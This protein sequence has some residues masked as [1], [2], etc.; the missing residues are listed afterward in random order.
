MQRTRIPVV[1]LGEGI[2]DGGVHVGVVDRP[3]ALSRSVSDSGTSG[4]REYL[5]R[6]ATVTSAGPS[7]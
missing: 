4:P 3:A 2:L 7:A 1:E 6:L 5:F